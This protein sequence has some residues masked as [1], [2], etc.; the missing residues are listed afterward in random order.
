VANFIET[1]GADRLLTV[2]LHAGQIQASSTSP[3]MSSQPCTS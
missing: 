3:W 2:D 1:A